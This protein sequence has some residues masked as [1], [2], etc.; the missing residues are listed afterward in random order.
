MFRFSSHLLDSRSHIGIRQFSLEGQKFREFVLV[1][2]PDGPRESAGAASGVSLPASAQE[3]LG[4]KSAAEAFCCRSASSL[5]RPWFCCRSRPISPRNRNSSREVP[6]DA[7]LGCFDCATR[8]ESRSFYVVQGASR[9]TCWCR[10]S[11]SA[12]N[13]TW[14]LG[15]TSGQP[16]SQ[17]VLSRAGL[18][19]NPPLVGQEILVSCHAQGGPLEG[20]KHVSLH[21]GYNGWKETADQP[22]TTVSEERWQVKLKLPPN[23]GEFDF[24]FTDSTRWDNNSGRDWGVPTRSAS[25]RPAP[26]TG[27]TNAM[28][29]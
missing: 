1:P 23:A 8:L 21:H 11:F 18:H 20:A 10:D 25:S 15:I 26:E 6:P 17:E 19:P 2:R 22:M 24:A 5:A 16:I 4:S 29:P 9:S 3:L 7:D 12:R 28:G 27:D 14:A 13:L